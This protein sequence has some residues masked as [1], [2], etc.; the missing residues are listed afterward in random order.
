MQRWLLLAATGVL[1]T[2][3][4]SGGAGS[5]GAATTGSPVST[6][7]VEGVG[8]VLVEAS[9][10]TLYYSRQ[11]EDGTVRC[12]GDCLGFWFPATTSDDST[13]TGSVADLGVVERPDNGQSQLTYQGKPLYSFKLDSGTGQANG[14]QVKDSFAGTDFEWFATSVTGTSATGDGGVYDGY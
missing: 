6:A 13:P 10:K 1:L 7:T 9:G 12:T 3:C 11:E 5:G 8:E 2:A 4:S 14:H